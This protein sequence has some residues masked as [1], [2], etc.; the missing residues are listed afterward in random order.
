MN[1]DVYRFD[2]GTFH[3]YAVSDGTYVYPDPAP[4]LFANAPQAQLEEVLHKHH[5]ELSQWREWLNTYTCLLVDTGQHRVL[6][7]T[8]GGTL[9]PSTGQLLR[10]LQTMAVAPADIDT[11]VLTHG[12]PDHVGGTMD[13]AGQTVFPNAQ[14]FMWR[15]EWDFWT[16][17]SDTVQGNPM[18]EFMVSFAQRHLLPVQSQIHLLEQ[19]GEIVPGIHAIAAPG[20][21]PGHMA[22]MIRSGEQ[23][24]LHLADTVAHPVHIE[25]PDWFAV[26]DLLPEQAVAT[27][28]HLLRCAGTEHSLVSAFHMPFPGIGYVMQDDEGWRWQPR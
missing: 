27:R 23:Q 21:T 19:E 3:C 24:L 17:A 13:E 25:H 22:L 8:G 11:V 15:T 14:F 2:V 10:N 26:V 28:R 1:R 4:T 16:T 6:I 12:H 20:H 7:D 18:L 5:I 9:A